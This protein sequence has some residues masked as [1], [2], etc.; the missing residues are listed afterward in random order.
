MTKDDAK[1]PDRRRIYLMRHGE[2]SYFHEGRPVP[3]EGVPLTAEGRE[4]AQAAAAALSEVP[5]DRAVSSGLP[6]TQETAAIVIGPR[7]LPIGTVPMLQEIRGGRLSDIPRADLRRVFVH[8]LSGPL[9]EADTFLAGETFGA[10]RDRVLPA[11]RSLIAD[12]TWRH[13][14]VVAHGGVNRVILADVLQAGLLG[15]GH[16]EQDPACINILD[17]DHKGHAIVRLLNHTP[18]N[19]TKDGL[20]LTTMEQYFRSFEPR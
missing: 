17:V 11:F 13:L 4:Q 20:F 7:P 19:P 8:A 12:P 15:L 10:F 3:P 14:L 5:F 9:T 6:R 2:V 16:M 18:Y 1:V